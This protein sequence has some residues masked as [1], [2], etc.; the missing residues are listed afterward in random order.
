MFQTGVV[1]ASFLIRPLLALGLGFGIYVLLPHLR[2]RELS[3][4]IWGA[5]F[6]LLIL[7]AESYVVSR[8]LAGSTAGR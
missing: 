5:V 2:G 4:L 3:L 1:L 7:G 6:Y 8:Q